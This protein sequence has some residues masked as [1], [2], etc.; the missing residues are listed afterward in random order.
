VPLD[1]AS[2]T[3]RKIKAGPNVQRRATLIVIIADVIREDWREGVTPTLLN[4]EA[5]LIAS[6][7]SGLCLGGMG[8]PDA[9][10][11]ALEIVGEA[12]TKAGAKRPAWKEGQPEHCDGG[13]IRTTRTTCAN[14]E[15]GLEPEQKIYCCKTCFDA[16]RARLYRA[17]NVDKFRAIDRLKNMRRR[18]AT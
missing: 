8:W 16:H 12:F 6:L 18:N 15:K 10:R 5:V 2:V 1:M 13:V 9:N 4:H 14:C 7:R 3:T 17:E 11:A